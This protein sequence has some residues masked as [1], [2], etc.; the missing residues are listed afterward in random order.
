MENNELYHYGI[1][2]M[3]WGHRKNYKVAVANAKKAYNNRNS[4]IQ[5][6][7]EM[8]EADIEKK[9]K[10]GQMLSVKDQNR[11]IAADNKAR[12]DWSKSKSIYKDEIRRAK[13]EYKAN[14]AKT[15]AEYKNNYKQLKKNDTAADKLLFNTAT[16]KKA[17]QYMT[18]NKMTM[19][20]ARKKAR[21]EAVRN[22]AVILGVIGGTTISKVAANRLMR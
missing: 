13:N 19:T 17:A 21:K 1:L 2:G 4:S 15:K 16:R 6:R 7:Y 14:V 10:R 3:K 9:Y 11:E 5:K 8:T 12:R 20:E 22:T 18:E